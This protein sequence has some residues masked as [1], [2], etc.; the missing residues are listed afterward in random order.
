M[1]VRPS[2]LLKQVGHEFLSAPNFRT[3]SFALER[4]LGGTEVWQIVGRCLADAWQILLGHR[5]CRAPHLPPDGRAVRSKTDTNHSVEHG[6]L[7]APLFPTR[8][9]KELPPAL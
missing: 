4:V 1:A 3:F 2:S 8:R 9:H 5:S 7:S 6:I